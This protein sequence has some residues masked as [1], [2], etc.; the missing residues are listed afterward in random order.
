MSKH[1]EW[2]PNQHGAWAFL[3]MPSLYSSMNNGVKVNHFIYLLAWLCAYCF[4][5]YYSLSFKTK[6]WDKRRK[7]IVIYLLVTSLLS[8]YLIFI[9]PSIIKVAPIFA[10]GFIAN[11]YFVRKKNERALINDFIGIILSAVVGYLIGGDLIGLSLISAYFIGT[12]FYVKT[13]IREKGNQKMLM[14]STLWHFFAMLYAF[15]NSIQIGELFSLLLARALFIP[16]TKLKP[17][18]IGMVEFGFTTMLL[19]ALLRFN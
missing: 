7:Q 10:A 3:V 1:N 4:N 12:V 8:L 13:M 17:K 11:L 6:N 18:Q 9:D 16:R 5:F 2:V 19:I 14:Y 15:V